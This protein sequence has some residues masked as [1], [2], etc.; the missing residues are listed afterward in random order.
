SFFEVKYTET[1]HRITMRQTFDV[2]LFGSFHADCLASIGLGLLFLALSSR[3]KPP[4]VMFIAIF[5]V[6]IGAFATGSVG[7]VVGGFL[8]LPSV[9]ALLLAAAIADRK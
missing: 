1:I 7:I 6:A 5:A 9:L 3:G 8:T 4:K 2:S